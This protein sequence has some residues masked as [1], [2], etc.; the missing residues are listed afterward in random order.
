MSCHL[1]GGR[2]AGGG[3]EEGCSFPLFIPAPYSFLRALGEWG[4][5]G[6]G[7]G[8]RP[9]TKE[10]LEDGPELSLTFSSPTFPGAA[11]FGRVGGWC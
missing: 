1:A 11:E 9:P 3:Q 6:A 10:E 8:T 5:F 7:M 2:W 4:Q